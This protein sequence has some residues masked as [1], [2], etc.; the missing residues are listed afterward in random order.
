MI[1][2]CVQLIS[3]VV[4]T[5]KFRCDAWSFN[6]FSLANADVANQYDRYGFSSANKEQ[7]LYQ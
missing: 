6:F 2:L 5:L 4:A 7:T 1:F 3:A